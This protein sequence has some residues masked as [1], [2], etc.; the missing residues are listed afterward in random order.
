MFGANLTVILTS[1]N[2]SVTS[3]AEYAQ[4]AGDEYVF[5]ITYFSSS[6]TSECVGKVRPDGTVV[7]CVEDGKSGSV[8]MKSQSLYKATVYKIDD[9]SVH[10][11]G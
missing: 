6:T 8:S 4:L 5:S 1:N 3:Y 7:K 2:A 10:M 11:K 9:H